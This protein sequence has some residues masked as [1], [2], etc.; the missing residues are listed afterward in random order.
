MSSS[1]SK[2]PPSPPSPSTTSSS[3]LDSDDTFNRLAALSS[4]LLASSKQILSTTLDLQSQVSR[5]LHSESP[6]RVGSS[7]NREDLDRKTREADGAKVWAEMNRL[8]EG[9]KLVTLAKSRQ[10]SD[11]SNF[12]N[13]TLMTLSIRLFH[14]PRFRSSLTSPRANLL[15]LH[16]GKSQLP[17]R[18]FPRQKQSRR[19]PMP[20]AELYLDHHAYEE[21]R[22]NRSS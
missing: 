16:S 8:E 7:L 13:S 17:N 12:A 14:L 20:S 9:V 3:S 4:S 15:L 18:K 10:V 19:N 1:T 5:F 22:C 21:Q 11:L 6:A 2:R